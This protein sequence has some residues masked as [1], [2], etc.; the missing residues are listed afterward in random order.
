VLLSYFGS[1]I[2]PLFGGSIPPHD[3]TLE[4]GLL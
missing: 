2:N 3:A 4:Y 1:S